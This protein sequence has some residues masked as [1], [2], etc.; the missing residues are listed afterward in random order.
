MQILT[1]GDGSLTFFSEEFGQAFHNVS[2]ARQEA[3]EKFVIPCHLKILPQH[4]SEI[5]LLDVCFGLGY[6]SGVALETI[7]QINPQ[8]RVML[9][10][11]ERSPSIPL[12]AWQAGIQ[13]GVG[14]SDLQKH[15]RDQNCG[16]SDLQKHNRDQNSNPRID[17]PSDQNTSQA[18]DRQRDQ[19]LAQEPDQP[20]APHFAS[21]WMTFLHQG[22]IN[23]ERFQGSLLWGDARQTIANVPDQWADAIFF[24][25]FSPSVCPEL[26]TV[27][28]FTQVGQRLK[29]QGHLATYSC[30]AAIR[31]A[32]IAAGLKIG[33]TPP[34]GR[35][36][37]GTVAS[38]AASDLLPPLSL[39]EQEHL[40]TRAA[41]PY[42]DLDLQATR[43]QII[44]A[45]QHEQQ[46]SR[47]EP[48][49]AW[50]RRWAQSPDRLI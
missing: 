10:G 46:R 4:Q 13:F 22:Q 15:N 47:L 31:S 7:W 44:Q 24:D 2:G 27:E 18:G 21:A 33:S 39:A 25:P 16:S 1:T 26:W 49:S 23:T 43:E 20:V 37:P 45:R 48:T 42:R 35:P 36:W 19:N 50:K 30:S 40:Q 5:H 29:P 38:P 41:V 11:L 6:N 12:A 17:H 8:C 28:F 14:S 32:M 3:L 9:I 34:I